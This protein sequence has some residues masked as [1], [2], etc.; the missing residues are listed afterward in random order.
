M[1]MLLVLPLLLIMMM[2]FVVAE[3]TVKTIEIP[4]GHIAQTVANNPYTQSININPPDKIAQIYSA[5]FV[6]KGDFQASTNVI[7]R[8]KQTGKSWQDCTPNI[9]V[10]PNM[11]ALNYEISFDCS[12]LAFGF[13]GG[14]IEFGIQTNKIAQNLRGMIKTTYYNDPEGV[15]D[16][17]GTEYRAGESARVFLQLKDN[18]GNPEN[19]GACAIDVYYPNQVNATATPYITNAPMLYLENSQ[20]LYY[21]DIN[22]LPEVEGVYM[23]DAG[24]NYQL[25]SAFVYNFDGTEPYGTTRYNTTGTFSS[26]TL[27]LNAYTDYGYTKCVATGG[28]KKHCQ[29]TY[30]FDT[31]IHFNGTENITDLSLY[32][33]GEASTD[34]LLIFEAYNY[35]NSSWMALPNNLT[36]SGESS[37]SPIGL[38]DFVSNDIEGQDF[39]SGSGIITIRVTG[40]DT[41]SFDQY[42]NLLN[43]NLK[44]A[45]G[46]I[47]ELKGSGEIHIHDWFDYYRQSYTDSHWTNFTGTINENVLGQMTNHTWNYNGTINSNLIT[48][49]VNSVWSYTGSI[50][51]NILNQFS[52]STWTRTNRNL[53]YYETDKNNLTAQNVWNYAERNLTHYEVANFTDLNGTSIAQAVWNYDG[54]VNDNVLN[55]VARKVRC[56]LTQL[57]STE[58][59][60]WSINI[61]VC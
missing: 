58:D 27:L 17:F 25:S 39:I 15:M 47:Q 46:I 42:D 8:V 31:T 16:I 6:I 36:F 5:E 21:Y 19:N 57:L 4:F 24:C 2:S 9:W 61:P 59:E 3:Q 52:D 54:T 38:N 26:T 13:K 49:F 50:I 12:D 55:Q 45:L 51:A 41:V 43:I 30:D 33:M 1:K 37:A 18:Q 11:N 32:Y 40:T 22:S 23:M 48:Q 60:E 35:S 20:G 34:A 56:Y 28:A 29:A 14:E 53:T 7:G 10:T 44:T